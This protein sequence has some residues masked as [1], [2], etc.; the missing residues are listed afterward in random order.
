M[1]VVHV[2][3]FRARKIDGRR[4]FRPVFSV[5]L[6]GPSGTVRTRMLVDSG[7]DCSL[8]DPRHAE[9]LG[10]RLEGARRGRVAARHLDVSRSEALLE[11]LHSSGWLSPIRIPVEV[12]GEPL[13][14]PFAVLGR[15]GFFEA[16]DVAFLLGPSPERGVFCLS[17]VER[18]RSRRPVARREDDARKRAR[19][20]A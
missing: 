5:R 6:R 1:S 4:I 12:P 9:S 18:R 17:P 16:F 19:I 20:A 7:A 15:E 2:F 11:V 3:P 14:I 13:G 8:I 10:L